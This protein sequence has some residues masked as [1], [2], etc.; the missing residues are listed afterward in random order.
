[1]RRVVIFDDYKELEIWPPGSF[2]KYLEITRKEVKRLLI[3]KGKLVDV[4][5]PA[6]SSN[7]KKIGFNKFGL[8]YVEC[9][10]CKT[11]YASP[12]PTEATI[13]KYIAESE[14]SKFWQSHIDKATLKGRIFHLF[15]PRAMW[16]ANLTEQYFKNPEVFVDINSMYNEFLEEIDMLNLFKNKIILV[17]TVNIA[18]SLNCERGFN[19]INKPFIKKD[20]SDINANVVTALAIIDRVFSPEK[21]ISAIKTML[22]KRGLFFFTATTISGFDLQVLW[23]N[24]KTIFPPDKINLLSIEG[25]ERLLER[26]GLEIIEVS[27]PGRLDVEFVK[28]AMQNNDKLKISRF[29]SY[30]LNNRDESAHSYFQDFLQKFKL[31]SHV[32]VA[33]RKR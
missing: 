28:E 33:A 21:F 11:L 22:T 6:C 20:Y 2:D 32:R 1:M 8:Q 9:M 29:I 7:K 23:S 14:A 16:V 5:C 4:P 15:R 18:E 30:L 25:I 24:A 3:D 27:T 10:D 26:C 19:V 12:R 31:C 13:N 17:P